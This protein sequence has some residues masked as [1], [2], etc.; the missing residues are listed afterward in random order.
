MEFMGFVGTYTYLKNKEKP[1][2]LKPNITV[3]GAVSGKSLAE[4]YGNISST[5][6]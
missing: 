2:K 1:K 4:E 6:F 3:S 5:I